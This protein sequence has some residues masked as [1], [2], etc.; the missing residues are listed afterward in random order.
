MDEGRQRI[1]CLCVPQMPLAAL[2]RAEPDICNHAVV[3][4]ASDESRAP[5]VAGNYE[6]CAE[7][8]LPG[9]T[10]V[11]ALSLL[12][13]LVVRPVCP[14]QVRSAQAALVD[15]ARSFSPRVA[16]ESS[17]EVCL[18][19]S[20]LTH[21]FQNERK[22]GRALVASARRAGLEI[23]VGI[24]S[25]RF[26]ALLAA[27]TAEGVKVV[28]HGAERDFLAP[29]PV[30]LLEASADLQAALMRF[31]IERL[32][33]LA[34]LP[35]RSLGRRLG[36]AGLSLWHKSRAEDYEPLVFEKS[37]ER[38]VE[39]TETA[40]SI[41]QV[42]PLLFVLQNIFQRLSE[43]IDLRGLT[44]R[45]LSLSLG[46]EP[47]GIDER[48]VELASPT[49]QVST[50]MMVTKLALEEQPP[51]AAVTSVCVEVEPVTLRRAQLDLFSPQGPAPAKLADTISRLAALSGE[52]RVGSPRLVNSHQPEDFCMVPFDS[53]EKSGQAALVRQAWDKQSAIKAIRP[54]EKVE[55]HQVRSLPAILSGRRFKGRVMQL[56][57][58]WRLDSGWWQADCLDRDYY[59]VELSDGGIYRLYHD[60]GKQQWFV[61]GICG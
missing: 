2:L 12:P 5:V 3:V 7:G 59:E 29:L 46:L 57:G 24:S 48:F 44:A 60:R 27:R 19:L 35:Q 16:L 37:T 15:V 20:G 21:L 1:G 13:D 28:A 55:V 36:S 53:R 6:A 14:A 18:D 26:V 56:A 4:T 39:E 40:H 25:T 22:L 45:R 38:F 32:G 54:P 9:M 11:Q 17:G 34:D 47:L 31:G 61:D 49:C 50:W 33:Q 8:I 41:Y 51:R 10:A 58:P 23:Q 43:R 42:E 52:D 30:T